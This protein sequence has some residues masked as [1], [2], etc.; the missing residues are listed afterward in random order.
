MIYVQSIAQWINGIKK[1]I[2]NYLVQGFHPEQVEL[3]L[4]Y[5]SISYVQ[6]YF[7]NRIVHNYRPTCSFLLIA[8]MM[9]LIGII[10]IITPTPA[11]T[12]GPIAMYRNTMDNTICNGADQI[13]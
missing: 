10:N 11:N 7:I 9:A 8:A 6:N 1:S 4:L 2:A 13:R 5:C 12:D 3:L